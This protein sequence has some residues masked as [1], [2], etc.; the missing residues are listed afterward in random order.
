MAGRNLLAG[1]PKGR[2]LLAPIQQPVQQAPVAPPMSGAG[3]GG[4][5]LRYD[6]PA[7]PRPHVQEQK[8]WG[9]IPG[10]ALGN[11]PESVGRLLIGL[12]EAVTHPYAT[13]KSITDIVAGIAQ[14]S[15]PGLNKDKQQIANAAGKFFSDRYGSIEGLKKTLAEDPAGVVA[16]LSAVLT[17]GGT[18]AAQAGAPGRIS[19]ALQKAGRYIDPVTAPLT[20]AAATAKI[21]PPAVLGTM[22]STG[23]AP[24]QEA[25]KSG[26]AGGKSGQAFRSNMRGGLAEMEA[27]LQDA[28]SGLAKMREQRNTAYRSG[29]VDISKDRTVLDFGEVNKAFNDAVADNMFNGV[30]KS[31]G[32][33]KSLDQINSELVEWSKR[34][35]E[36]FHTPEGL[37]ALKQRIGDLVDW[38]NKGDKENRALMSMYNDIKGIIEKQ[39]PAYSKTMRDYSEASRQIIELEKSLSLGNNA[40]ADT[41]LRKL[42][43][44]MRNNVNTNYGARTA[45]LDELQTASGKPL[46]PAVAGQAMNSWTPRGLSQIGANMAVTGLAGNLLS[47][48]A[49]ATLPAQSPR[50]VGEAAHAAGRVSGPAIKGGRL[51]TNLMRRA[52]VTPR[53]LT[54]AAYQSGRL[55]KELKGK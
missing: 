15:I 4:T 38:K 41:A 21:A 33:A 42:S 36:L 3:P 11:T 47:P 27:T 19:G 25:F 40:G 37:D 16:D 23:M 5:N 26:V 17:M 54:T 49:L 14:K 12:K 48:W 9:D 29:M 20:L 7:F 13:A 45:H 39:A 32:A 55:Q 46:V 24:V 28:K 51:A 10:E 35:P 52:G 22:S 53:G 44:V 18:A 30:A 34:D 8:Q 6:D 43:S 50:L 2:N 1:R 31:E